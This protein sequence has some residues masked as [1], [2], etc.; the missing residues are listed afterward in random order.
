MIA[1]PGVDCSLLVVIPC[2][3]RSAPL[4]TFQPI[5]TAIYLCIVLSPGTCNRPMRKRSCSTWDAD[6]GERTCHE[7]P[8]SLNASCRLLPLLHASLLAVGLD[9]QEASMTVVKDLLKAP[10]AG[11]SVAI[12]SERTET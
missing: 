6:S 1:M 2:K 8:Q 7:T 4:Q 5:R 3:M 11:A 10:W 9:L 12:T